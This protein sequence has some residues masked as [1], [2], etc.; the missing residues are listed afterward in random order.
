MVGLS[1]SASYDGKHSA[2]LTPDDTARQTAR[3]DGATRFFFDVRYLPE[4]SA[5]EILRRNNAAITQLGIERFSAR[6]G[7]LQ[8]ASYR[9]VRFNSLRLFGLISLPFG[10]ACAAYASI[11]S[12]FPVRRQDAVVCGPCNRV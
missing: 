4:N 5:E 3:N 10:K 11:S 8:L 12:S 9:F 6:F 2:R 7:T 1:R